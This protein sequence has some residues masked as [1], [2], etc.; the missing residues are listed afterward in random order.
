MGELFTDG[1]NA[2]FGTDPAIT[3]EPA[4]QPEPTVAPTETPVPTATPL[5]V[6]DQ[7]SPVADK[8]DTSGDPA[9]DPGT[10]V[11]DGVEEVPAADTVEQIDYTDLLTRQ[12]EL[13]EM[14]I[15]KD[16]KLDQDMRTVQ[17]AMPA[18]MCMMG[19][20]VGLLLLQILASYIRP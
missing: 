9:A 15:L 14:I 10:E 18:V 5:P 2:D 3:P 11:S 19:V 20:I 13:L 16:E 8:V 17:N 1:T 6:P 7:Q 12:N 4:V